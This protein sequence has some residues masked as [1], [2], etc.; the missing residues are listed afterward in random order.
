[1]F[2]RIQKTKRKLATYHVGLLQTKAY[3]V[4]NSRATESLKPFGISSIEWAFLGA[5]Y[6]YSFESH[7]GMRATVLAKVLGVEAPF[8]TELSLKLEAKQLIVV[9]QDE[10][11]K[12]VRRISLNEKGKKFVPEVEKTMY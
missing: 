5:L 2:E 10:D 4:L 6:E 3:R 9:L 8:V 1:M 11:D 12:R 7:I